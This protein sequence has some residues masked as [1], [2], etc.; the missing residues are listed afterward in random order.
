MSKPMLR[1]LCAVL[2]AVMLLFSFQTVAYA[3]HDRYDDDDGSI[4]LDAHYHED[5][6]SIYFLAG[7]TYELT[8]IAH[9]SIDDDTL[10]VTYTI[11]DAYK[12]FD[13]DWVATTASQR[14]AIAKELAKVAVPDETGVTDKNGK[15][16]FDDLKP[17]LY[18][19]VRSRVAEKNK[20][21]ILDPYLVTLP[22][23]ED[24]DVFEDIEVDEKF[25]RIGD[26]RPTPTPTITP[27]PSNSPLPSES[28]VP[29]AQPTPTPN[30]ETTPAPVPSAAPTPVGSPQV[31]A[32]RLPQTGQ[33][34]WP[35]PVLLIVGLALILLGAW[36]QRK[37]DHEK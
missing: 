31:T 9:K 8:L 10:D 35:I 20:D 18:L 1:S 2:F 15:L 27:V 33:L 30:T 36:L 12:D 37:S 7:D 14:L 22:I 16:T 29:S 25:A 23:I 5:D 3:T 17:G 13:C 11:V 24:G 34:N 28:P 6:G 4:R 21:Y 32:G 19:I 26:P